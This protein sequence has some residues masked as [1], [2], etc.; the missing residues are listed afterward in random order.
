MAA[1]GEV[2]G[3]TGQGEEQHDGRAVARR[4]GV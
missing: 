3:S 4:D 1:M 2:M